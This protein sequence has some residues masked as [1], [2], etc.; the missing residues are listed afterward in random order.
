[1]AAGRRPARPA[2]TLSGPFFTAGHSTRSADELLALLRA[3][4]VPR[5]VDVRRF[6]ASRR[7]PQFSKEALAA[8]L[9]AS[10]IAYHHE[11]DLGGHREPRADSPNTAWRNP[12]FR[13]YADH[14]ATPDFQAALARLLQAPPRT[15]LLCAEAQ[16]TRCHRQ[17]IA[18]ALAARGLAVQHLLA[19]GRAETHVLNPR[20]RPGPAGTL[21]YPAPGSRQATLFDS[22]PR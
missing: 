14:M 9:A 8:A 1:M 20:A 11:P 2:S 12:A 13:G 10:G 7:H 18:D 6:P 15:A 22:R 16:P 19:P 3:A 21:T 17:L 4:D 5:L